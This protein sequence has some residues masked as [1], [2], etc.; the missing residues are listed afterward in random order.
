M[1]L[2]TKKHISGEMGMSSMTDIIFIL[3]MFFMM[4][5]TLTMP[6]AL[7]LA[8]PSSN[9]TPPIKVQTKDKLT[10]V[11]ILSDG[12]F[13]LDGTA[14]KIEEIESKLKED[15]TKSKDQVN[16]LV[17][18]SNAS[19]VESVVTILDLTHKL[20]VNAILDLQE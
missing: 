16:I 14:A 17:S 6:S 4:T 9:P 10:H 8:L 20:S 15:I 18:P 3:L 5:S 12:A 19:P 2:R 1:G 11:N 7:S 13:M